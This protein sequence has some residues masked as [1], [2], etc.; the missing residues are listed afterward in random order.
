MSGFDYFVRGA[1]WSCGLVLAA[2]ISPLIV[3]LLALQVFGAGL[4]GLGF[5]MVLPGRHGLRLLKRI[6]AEVDALELRR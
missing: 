3:A 4:Q 2:A 1:A 6:L 5:L